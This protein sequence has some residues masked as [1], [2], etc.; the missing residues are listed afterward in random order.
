MYLAHI[1]KK[2]ST[3]YHASAVIRETAKLRRLSLRKLVFVS[4]SLLACE[5]NDRTQCGERVV[6]PPFHLA[7]VAYLASVKRPSRRHGRQPFCDEVSRLGFLVNVI[8]SARLMFD[9]E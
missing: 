1:A 7:V 9:G 3:F 2:Q 5:I 6:V 8:T 4:T